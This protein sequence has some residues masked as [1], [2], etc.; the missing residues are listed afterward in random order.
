MNIHKCIYNFIYANIRV[1]FLYD[2]G[3]HLPL[4]ISMIY[5][6]IVLLVNQILWCF[7]CTSHL[8]S[9]IKVM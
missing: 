3:N 6:A 8:F 2:L 5:W 7:I 4:L 1:Y 9:F